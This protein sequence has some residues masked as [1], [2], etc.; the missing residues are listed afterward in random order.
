MEIEYLEE[1]LVIAEEGRLGEAAERLYTTS[2]SLSKHIH[3][4]EKEYGVAL[5]DRSKRTIALNA[6]GEMLLPYAKKMVE[7]HREASRKLFQK[8]VSDERSVSISAGYRI[9]EM[10]VEFR[11][12]YQIGLTINESYEGKELLRKGD[13]ELAFIMDEENKEQDLVKLP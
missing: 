8:A 9:F 4:L 5:F 2:S 10:A 12:K 1:F 13:C 6:Y 3:A 11:Q 7:L